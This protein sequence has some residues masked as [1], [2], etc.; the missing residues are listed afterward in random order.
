[1]S[2]PINVSYNN[3]ASVHE[4]LNKWRLRETLAIEIFIAG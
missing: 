3:H 4:F 2:I 1:M